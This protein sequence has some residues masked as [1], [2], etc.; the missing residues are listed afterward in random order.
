MSI[1]LLDDELINKI[2]AG[3]VVERPAS[4]VKELV[5]NALDAEARHITITI[6]QAGLEK[7]EVED[8]G[9]GMSR[10]EIPLAFMRHATSKI[11]EEEDLYCITTMGF[12]GEALP[13]IAAVSRIDIYSCQEEGEGVW[14]HLEGGKIT[15]IDYHP[16]P[17]GTRIIVR[18]IFY[19]TPAR[20]KFLKSPVAESSHIFELVVKY[21]LSRPDIAFTYRGDKKIYFKTPG[22]GNLRDAVLAIYGRDFL[23]PLIDIE[24]KGENYSIKGLISRP[25]VKRNNRKN[26]LFFVNNRPVRSQ[27]LYKAV[28]E[29]Y[30]GLL[31][32]REYPVVILSL[33]MPPYEVDVN[34]H[35]QKTEVRF[36]D[37]GKVFRLVYQVLREH[38][39]NLEYQG[40]GEWTKNKEDLFFYPEKEKEKKEP[41]VYIREKKLPWMED[42][43]FSR[44]EKSQSVNQPLAGG[45]EVLELV[46]NRQAADKE[47]DYKILGQVL[48]KYILLERDNSLYI[49]DQH[50]AHERVL[51]EQF[52]KQYRQEKTGQML[53]F[54]LS[55]QLSAKQVEVIE[56]NADLLKDLGFEL[57]IISYNSAVLRT[58]P[59]FIQ[60][61]EF[62]VMEEI[63]AS[64]EEK[65]EADLYD[66]ILVMMACQ[67]AVKAGDMLTWMEMDKMVKDLWETDNFRYC[68]HGRPTMFKITEEELNNIFKR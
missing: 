51:Y 34:V 9:Q 7:I 64:L 21:A 48:K 41:G 36:R 27:L 12:R 47:S 37:D 39:D 43:L 38:L 4:V 26:Q 32:T 55:L 54:P 67:K 45:K 40:I 2:A 50:A 29:A 57:D 5:E 68:P 6:S 42:P 19:N 63:L 52:K 44:E 16:C 11:K 65:G 56:K 17:K 15:S 33:L 3:E 18:D 20:R 31:V 24:Y 62:Q 8:D 22:N 14:A 30:K 10:E 1:R 59:S 66:N 61:S 53:A 58:A 49:I 28:D 35:P 25:E 13:S 60:G 23:S 46:F